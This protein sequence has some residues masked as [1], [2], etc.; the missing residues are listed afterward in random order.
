MSHLATV[1]FVLLL[2]MCAVT[3]AAG[4]F[5]WL[6][7]RAPGARVLALL[8]FACALN[9]GAF[10]LEF[11]TASLTTKVA[12]EKILIISSA[13]IPTLWFVFAV[14]YTG[15]GRHLTRTVLA[16]LTVVPLISFL[17]ALSNEAH[18][19]FWRGISLAPGDAYLGAEL[20]FGPA[21]W[22]HIVYSNALLA[23]GTVL[24]L[25]LFWRSWSLY[26]G[27][28]IALLVA[29][30]I[31]WLAQS[32]YLGGLSPVPGIDLVSVGF[33]VAALL[34]AV[35][36]SRLRAADVL[37]VSRAA[38]LGSLVD[39]VMVLDPDA[40]VLYS[41]PA[42]VAFLEH[43]ASEALPKTLAGVWPQAFDAR[44]GEPGRVT[45]LATVSWRDD[46]ASVFD[47]SLSP[48]VDG[49]GQAVAKLLVVRDV[50]EQR[51]AE[52]E[53]RGSGARLDQALDAT[54][55]ALSAA[56]ESR[57]PYTLG[58]QR[59]VATLARAIA[60][61]LGMDGERLRGLCVAAE[62]HDVGKIQVPI[63]ILSRP[64]RLTDGEFA[65]V[66]EHAESGYQILKGIAFPW[67]V[68]RIVR[69]HHEKLDGSGYPLG[70]SAN[71][72]LLEA[73]ILCIADVVE[74]MASDRP[75][76]PSLGVSAALEEVSLHSGR[77]F[78]PAAVDAC[79]RVF[80]RGD[81]QF[82]EHREAGI[83]GDDAPEGRARPALVLNMSADAVPL[84][85]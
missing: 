6:R 47:L 43:V 54:V 28:A 7:V 73:R 79:T 30:S 38:I 4:V 33:C 62:V 45:E 8:L 26:R 34:L 72:I 48:V 14:Q 22:V 44:K 71:D 3:A 52:E 78:D 36:F 13:T 75:Y 84:N 2:G 51:R 10:A 85:R 12:V 59:R 65:L 21:F 24:L 9:S 66:K 29:V 15:R 17:L 57:D 60:V 77:L 56:V 35:G 27:Q 70:L 5:V 46:D 40:N 16:L 67:P 61:E 41:N 32:M 23:A 76:R 42:G 49:G 68:A 63:E 53:L 74:A 37:T 50:T 69:Q 81:F 19:L 58:H 80:A 39:A 83:G 82:S 20:V 25:Q 18:H 31:P 1:N 55:Q 64:G 11:A